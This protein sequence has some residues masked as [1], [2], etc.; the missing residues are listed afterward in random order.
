M[1]PGAGRSIVGRVKV[2][3]F[4]LF[5]SGG[6]AA[7]SSM[8]A[9]RLAAAEAAKDPNAS[10]VIAE[11]ALERGDCRSASETYAAAAQRGDVSIARRSTEVSLGCEHLPAA[12]DSVK[13]WRSLAPA[14]RDAN[15]I[16]AT[17]ALKLYRVPEARTAV[18]TLLKMPP[19][20]DS[21]SDAK[22]SALGSARP[23][24]S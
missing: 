1:R 14:D 24:D 15:A 12:W 11:I 9:G 17:V 23:L 20:D 4:A 21:K 22:D 13:R 10:T 2:L 19:E 3:S 16:F 7:A 8:A 18:T 6:L 5:L